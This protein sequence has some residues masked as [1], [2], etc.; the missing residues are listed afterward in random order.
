MKLP[1]IS[2][3]MKDWLKI[4][5]VLLLCVWICGVVT[6]RD[7]LN[8]TLYVKLELD[9]PTVQNQTQSQF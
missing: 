5:S 9:R 3:D 8:R 4:F 2:Q 7:Q 6:Y 1:E